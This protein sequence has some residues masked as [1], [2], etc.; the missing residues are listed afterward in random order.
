MKLTG[1]K[2]NISIKEIA[3]YLYFLLLSPPSRKAFLTAFTVWQTRC[4]SALTFV[5]CAYLNDA[6]NGEFGFWP[7]T[8]KFSAKIL[9]CHG[10]TTEIY[11]KS[12]NVKR[13]EIWSSRGRCVQ[14]DARFWPSM[15][16]SGNLELLFE[17]YC[18][19]SYHK[20]SASNFFISVEQTKMRQAESF[21]NGKPSTYIDKSQE[22]SQQRL[23][24]KIDF[25]YAVGS[26]TGA[27]LSLPLQTSYLLVEDKI[28]KFK[29]EIW[30]LRNDFYA[31]Y[32]VISIIHES[33]QR[34]ALK[35]FSSNK[36]SWAID[37]VLRSWG[38]RTS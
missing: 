33:F 7:Y 12:L 31:I 13:K 36:I 16:F 23:P 22:T 26:R 14:C 28:E 25:K 6:P 4:R 21:W 15:C 10:L 37:W 27:M 9:S 20:V 34:Y 29:G 1:S 8:E 2:V 24:L 3:F 19:T 18:V 32:E 35:L 30:F 5:S 11:S 17:P 38:K